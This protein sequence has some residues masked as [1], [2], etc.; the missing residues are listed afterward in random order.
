MLYTN[1]YVTTYRIKIV[2]FLDSFSLTEC[3]EFFDSTLHSSENINSAY[4]M[5]GYA[6]RCRI[7]IYSSVAKNSIFIIK[8]ALRVHLD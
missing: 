6:N 3:S 1:K 8:F 4:P 5:E 2:Y 7:A